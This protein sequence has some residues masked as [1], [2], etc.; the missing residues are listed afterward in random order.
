M[1][2]GIYPVSRLGKML[3]SC[4]FLFSK[5]WH[6]VAR[7]FQADAEVLLLWDQC[8][9]VPVNWLYRNKST[10]GDGT[11]CCDIDYLITVILPL[12]RQQFVFHERM[13][14]VAS[15]RTFSLGQRLPCG[16]DILGASSCLEGSQLSVEAQSHCITW[17]QDYKDHMR[18]NMTG[19][20]EAGDH[21]W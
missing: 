8:L 9:L 7:L 1:L 13:G 19:N 11:V 18:G 10:A 20:Q 15:H 5:Q 2:G 12:W 21:S 6:I 14:L 16:I 3:F 17:R 4:F